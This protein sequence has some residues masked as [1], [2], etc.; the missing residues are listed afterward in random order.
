MRFFNI[1]ALPALLLVTIISLAPSSAEAKTFETKNVEEGD[2]TF[3]YPNNWKS[4]K[5]NRFHS[6]DA[7]V[8][9]GNNDVQMNFESGSPFDYLIF[10]LNDT[11]SAVNSLE[12][13]AETLYDGTVEES[14]AD[15]YT[16]NGNPAPYTIVTYQSEPGFFGATLDM[17]AQVTL[18]QLSD[19]HVAL[20]QYVTEEDD[21]DKYLSKAEQILE[22]IKP[23]GGVITQSTSDNSFT[24]E[25]DDLSKTKAICDTV[26]TQSDKDLCET[27][28]N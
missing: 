18:V 21:F 15:K 17:A 28:L 2:Y 7:R 9:L 23:I 25:E 14:G 12:T 5:L 19:D 22:S 26:T 24:S 10:N 13:I 1:S 4:Q 11:E 20:V 6:F 16:I 3:E 27:L 8:V